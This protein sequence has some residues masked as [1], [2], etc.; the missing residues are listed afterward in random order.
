[1]TGGT[2]DIALFAE[3]ID[4]LIPMMHVTMVWALPNWLVAYL[5][6]AD[7]VMLSWDVYGW[8]GTGISL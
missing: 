7:Y 8:A 1:M 2:L 4:V 5:Q 6:H 3:R